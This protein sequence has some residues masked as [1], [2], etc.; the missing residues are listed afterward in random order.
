M[1]PSFYH[2]GTSRAVA[3]EVL[4]CINSSPDIL[5]EH[6]KPS[7]RAAGDA[8]EHLIAEQ[9][10]QLLGDRGSDFSV[11][12]TRKSMEDFSFTDQ[13]GFYSA[14]DVKTHREGADFS[15]PNLVSVKK[16]ARFY[17][18]DMNIFSLMLVRYAVKGIDVQAKSVVFCPIEFLDWE[19]LTIG[20]LGEGQVQIANS[21]NIVVN[22]GFSR[23][24]WMLRLCDTLLKF[25][26]GEIEKTKRR[27]KEFQDIKDK[28]ETREDA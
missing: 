9:F 4:E 6:T 12:T 23:R 13:E 3:Q 7:T 10:G 11:A 17:E 27:I 2:D 22:E 28:W 19:C 14:V 5:S 15:M 18:N 21:A 26:P 20:A 1:K 25:Y 16:L 24:E 8:I